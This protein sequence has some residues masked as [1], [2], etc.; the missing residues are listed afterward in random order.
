MY[1]SMVP[2]MKP[3]PQVD[4]RVRRKEILDTAARLFGSSGPRTSVRE[5]ADAC[6]ILPGSLYHHFPSKE[7][8]LVE[9]VKRYQ[10]ELDSIAHDVLED[11]RRSA[12][13]PVVDRIVTVA[14]AIFDCALRHRAGLFQTLYDPPASA[15][16]ELVKA[17]RSTPVVV[18]NAI[19]EVLF[20]ARTAGLIRSTVDLQR[21]SQQ[22]CRSLLYTTPD[23]IYDSRVALQLPAVKCRMLLE[24]LS[25]RQVDSAVLDQS[26]AYATAAATIAGWDR[27]GTDTAADA[28]MG[29]LWSVARSEFGRRGYEATTIRDVAAAAGMSTGTVYRVIGSKNDLLESI[30]SAYLRRVAEGWNAVLASDSTPIEKLDALLWLNIN[31][32]DRF[33]DDYKI[34]LAWFR[35][36]PVVTFA[37]FA[38]S[39]IDRLKQSK[40]L[41]AEGLRTGLIRASPASIEIQAHSLLELVWMPEDLVRSAGPRATLALARDSL[42]RG[43]IERA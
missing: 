35:P 39:Y 11:L 3:S 15:G 12:A 28:R 32:L 43:A 8:I 24:G 30:M 1:W 23:A 31:V 20:A 9:L 41:L 5:I 37:H 16:V 33:G 22:I 27:A 13:T 7:A 19:L 18:D 6:G 26:K 4:E 42:L 36:N 17:A 34:Q 21:L 40:I 29:L 25:A 2:I 10:T 38:Q 14:E